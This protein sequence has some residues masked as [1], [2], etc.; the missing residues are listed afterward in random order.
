M[1]F[2]EYVCREL[3]GEPVYSRGNG[4]SSWSCPCHED[5]NPSFV[6]RTFVEGG[7]HR[8]KC[9]SCGWWGDELD[10]LKECFPT[11]NFDSRLRRLDELRKAY[12]KEI[13]QPTEPTKQSTSNSYS[14]DGGVQ[15]Q[16]ENNPQH[17]AEAWSSIF[18]DFRNEEVV[19]FYVLEKVVETCKCHDIDPEALLQ[20]WKEFNES[21]NRML[22]D[23]I[24][25]CVDPLCGDRCR[26]ARGLSKLSKAVR[27][28]RELAK[29]VRKRQ[30][31][32]ERKRMVKKIRANGKR[33]AR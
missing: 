7:H 19:A 23:H 25:T 32:T 26:E 33:L 18:G 1:T 20:Y 2:L 21:M 31:A 6:T 28:K 24:E 16:R 29:R 22:L 17:V 30:A 4:V 14:G 3:I 8:F 10:V 11:E 12:K 27:E 15:T 9:F 5:E 13:R